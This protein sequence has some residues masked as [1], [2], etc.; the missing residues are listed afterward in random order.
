MIFVLL[1]TSRSFEKSYQMSS[2]LRKKS[3]RIR[4]TR[5]WFYFSD[6]A[7][8]LIDSWLLYAELAQK[9]YTAAILSIEVFCRKKIKY[10][11]YYSTNE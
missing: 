9:G 4:Y 6:L 7:N 3:Q 1:S 5:D 11:K 2:L 8:R 10:M